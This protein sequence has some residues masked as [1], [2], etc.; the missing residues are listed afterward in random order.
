M[1]I[2]DELDYFTPDEF[3]YPDEMNEEFLLVLDLVRER[4]GV[5]FVITSDYRPGDPRAHG[6]GL[7]VDIADD[8]GHDGISS[9]FR[10]KVVRAALQMGV[11]RI[12]V[13]DK[14]VHLD[15]WEDGPQEVLWTGFST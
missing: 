5:P 10:F 12:G 14:H 2:W 1:A 3:D 9:T 4:A 6:H 11:R 13:Y 7:A 8:Q 15:C